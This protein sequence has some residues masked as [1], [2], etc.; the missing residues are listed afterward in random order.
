MVIYYVF[1]VIFFDIYHKIVLD[2]YCMFI[3]NIYYR[4]VYHVN[5]KM[6]VYA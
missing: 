1:F 4:D 5:Y 2:T 6:L 3:N